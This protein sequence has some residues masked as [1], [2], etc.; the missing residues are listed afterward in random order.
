MGAV[1]PLLGGREMAL[2]IKNV[3]GRNAPLHQLYNSREFSGS[4]GYA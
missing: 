4:Q 2:L 3:T 1:T